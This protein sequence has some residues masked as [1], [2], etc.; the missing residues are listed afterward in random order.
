MPESL[1]LESILRLVGKKFMIVS[2]LLLLL[3][4]NDTFL[5]SSIFKIITNWKLSLRVGRSMTLLNKSKGWD[6]SHWIIPNKQ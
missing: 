2:K 4:L 3:S 6:S 5:L 1:N